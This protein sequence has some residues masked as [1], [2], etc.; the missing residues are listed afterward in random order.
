M[1]KVG[2]LPLTL[3][4]VTW[5]TKQQALFSQ[6]LA[7]NCC[8]VAQSCPTLCDPMDCST[9]GFP[10]H[11]HLLELAHTYI[12]WVGDAIQ[13][14]HPMSSP[15]PPAFKCS[16]YQGVF[17]WVNSLHQVAKVLELQFQHQ[18]FQEYSELDWYDLP[19]VQGTLKGL[20]QHHSSK[21][22]VHD[23]QPSL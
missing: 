12:H 3:N 2:L 18:S 11:Y 8:S 6:R 22:S 14:S 23:S 15:S 13:P 21:T 4:S 19:D 10:V 17:Q 5:L 1:A 20:L 7:Y 9:P 16:Q